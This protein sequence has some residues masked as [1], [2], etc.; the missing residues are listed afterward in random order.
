MSDLKEEIAEIK[1]DIRD[2][3]DQLSSN[4]IVTAKQQ[5]ILEEHMKRSEMLEK[6]VNNQGNVFDRFERM[7]KANKSFVYKVL[8]GAIV[9]GLLP[10]L[11]QL[12]AIK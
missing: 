2:I 5:A 1:V 6:I 9:S 3:K 4:A 8:I 10:F 12:L 11:I 7:D